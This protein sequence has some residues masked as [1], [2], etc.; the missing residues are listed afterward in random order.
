MAIS[1][2]GASSLADALRSN[3]A[4]V[5]IDLKENRIADAG[6]SALAP[7]IRGAAPLPCPPLEGVLPPEGS[8]LV[9]RA[10]PSRVAPL[11]LT[12][13]LSTARPAARNVGRRVRAAVQGWRGP[14]SRAAAACSQGG[15]QGEF[16]R[17]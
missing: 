12:T 11:R 16:L 2:A 3:A 6:A 14:A 8:S 13:G 7:A 10:N 4:L 17:R 5:S 1:D 15:A 9:R